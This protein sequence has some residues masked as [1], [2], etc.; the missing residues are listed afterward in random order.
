MRGN[1]KRHLLVD[2]DVG[3]IP[4]DAGEPQ[5]HRHRSRYPGDYPR[6]C[7]GTGR[8]DP[9]ATIFGGLSP[10]MRGNLKAR[11]DRTEGRG[12]IPADAGEPHCGHR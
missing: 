5:P 2:A 12:T 11:Y 7:G 8:N 6:G 9:H 10:R 4:A 3:T 1:P